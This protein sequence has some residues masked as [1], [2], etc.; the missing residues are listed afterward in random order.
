MYTCRRFGYAL[1]LTRKLFW[2]YITLITFFC[3]ISAIFWAFRGVLTLFLWVGC[4]LL[5]Q[6]AG[7]VGLK[8]TRLCYFDMFNDVMFT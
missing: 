3:H 1:E 7:L 8:E 6:V 5:Y 2:N 4:L